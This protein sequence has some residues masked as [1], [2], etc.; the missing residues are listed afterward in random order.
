MTPD[1]K[2][3]TCSSNDKIYQSTS[4]G[5]KKVYYNYIIHYLCFFFVLSIL[6][7]LFEQF[8][9]TEDDP[10]FD[11]L[12]RFQ[13]GRMDDQR[14]SLGSSRSLEDKE[15]QNSNKLVAPIGKHFIINYLTLIYTVSCITY[16]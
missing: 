4:S 8:D 16:L 9:K 11:L 1:N 7:C 15:N 13:A 2:G 3:K 10:F 6:K 14:C 5:S 12:S